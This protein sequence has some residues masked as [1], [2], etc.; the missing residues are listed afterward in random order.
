MRMRFGNPAKLVIAIVC[1]ALTIALLEVGATLRLGTS[2]VRGRHVEEGWIAVARFDPSLGW[3]NRPHASER[4][5]W[6]SMDY[7]V[8]VNA[9]GFRDIERAEQKPDGVRR[10]VLLGD[11]VAWGWGVDADERFGDMLDERLGEDVEVLNLACPGYGTDQQYWTLLDRGLAYEPDVV[12]VVFVLNDVFE[13]RYDKRYKMSKPRFTLQADGGW[14]VENRPV[15]ASTSSSWFRSVRRTA[16]AQSAL[17]AWATGRGDPTKLGPPTP[18]TYRPRTPESLAPVR[19]AADS[20][21]DPKGV[22]YFLLEQIAELCADEG[23]ELITTLVPHKHDQYLY[24][25]DFPRPGDLV[26][27]GYRTHATQC[28]EEVGSTVGFPVIPLD[29]AFLREVDKGMRLHV[30]DGHLNLEGHRVVADVLEPVLLAVLDEE[31]R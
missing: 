24:E 2:F 13:A 21:R 19:A 28:L 18:K 17:L 1:A 22:T 10:V 3:S 7:Q 5:A 23:I 31:Q 6:S 11:S 30:G 25:P 26:E 14:Q 29:T 15:E 8:E 4:L 27:G 20:I 16:V 12:V 9:T